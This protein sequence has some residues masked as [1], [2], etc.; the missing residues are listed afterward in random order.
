MALTQTPPA[1]EP[2]HIDALRTA[3]LDDAAISDVLHGTA[4]FNWA[5]RLMLSLGE[6]QL[7]ATAPA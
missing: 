3:G 6:P 2:A 7:P 5:N 4:F 1:L